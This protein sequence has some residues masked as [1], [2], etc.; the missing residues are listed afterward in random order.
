[1]IEQ[2]QSE[3][4]LLKSLLCKNTFEK[5][6]G[7]IDLRVVSEDFRAIYKGIKEAHSCTAG[8]VTIDTVAVLVQND[9]SCTA[10]KWTFYK[11]V[12]EAMSEV[13]MLDTDTIS[14]VLSKVQDKSVARMIAEKATNVILGTE[15]LEN[16]KSLVNDTKIA[17][18]RKIEDEA[19]DVDIESAFDFLDRGGE[20][21][22]TNGLEFLEENLSGLSL[23]RGCLM[24]LFAYSNV[25]KS[26]FVAQ[27]SIGLL[28][29][30][31]KVLY[32][33]NEDSLRKILLNFYRSYYNVSDDDLKQNRTTYTTP[34]EFK[35]LVLKTTHSKN[36]NDLERE[37]QTES[38]DV[39]IFDQT[40]N[41]NYKLF[42]DNIT[43]SIEKLYQWTRGLAIGND[44]LVVNVTQASNESNITQGKDIGNGREVLSQ[45]MMKDSKVGKAGAADLIIGIGS[46]NPGS[47]D[48]CITSCKNKINGHHKSIFCKIN[49]LTARYEE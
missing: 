5:L 3:L 45:N 18:P 23:H 4:L 10:A 9:N 32:Y 47:Y 41:I 39:I 26:T 13:G 1:M 48:R 34:P 46:K 33:G 8:D 16:L 49:P 24:I 15:S 31:H 12:L 25:G 21:K 22:F 19:I 14:N 29:Q 35:N 38:P 28:Q 30:G 42:A 17:A 36:L 2:E 20:F 27:Y 7:V 44:C 11:E 40:D 43:V 37:I 6:K